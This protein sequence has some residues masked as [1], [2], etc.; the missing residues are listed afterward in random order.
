MRWVCLNGTT[1]AWE[2]QQLLCVLV[3]GEAILCFAWMWETL[4]QT[5]HLWFIQE[6]LIWLKSAPHRDFERVNA[7]YSVPHEHVFVEIMRSLFYTWACFMVSQIMYRVLVTILTQQGPRY[8][9]TN[10][11]RIVCSWRAIS[12][13]RHGFVS[14]AL[15]DSH[16]NTVKRWAAAWL[17]DELRWM[18]IHIWLCHR[19][20]R[21]SNWSWEL[22][23][24]VG[25]MTAADYSLCDVPRM[26]CSVRYSP[27]ISL[28]RECTE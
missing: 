9:F 27:M 26:Q 23:S 4:G 21:S 28:Q 3:L 12:Y 2:W 7:S 13:V 8:L 16:S 18:L 22:L 10:E 20:R 17:N 11:C 25:W 1:V 24:M 14:C 15:C 19:L 5:C 6:Y